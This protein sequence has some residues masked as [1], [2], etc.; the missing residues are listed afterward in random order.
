MWAEEKCTHSMSVLRH[1]LL[2]CLYIVFI[3]PHE[4]KILEDPGWTGVQW[5]LKWVHGNCVMSVTS[6]MGVGVAE[7]PRWPH[8]CS[9]VNFLWMQNESDGVLRNTNHQGTLSYSFL[10]MLLPCIHNYLCWKWWSGRKGKNSV[11]HNCFFILSFL[12]HK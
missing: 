12:T 5:N 7:S 10:F 6:Q 1:F 9:N 4:H 2:P 8:F 3:M 11:A